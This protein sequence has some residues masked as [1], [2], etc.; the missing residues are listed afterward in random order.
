M[1]YVALC[2]QKLVRRDILETERKGTS[3]HTERAADVRKD[4]CCGCGRING[5]SVLDG[6]V[7]VRATLSVLTP[8]M[9]RRFVK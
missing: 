6:I 1:L 5:K 9:D 4:V 2:R 7:V 8:E 3:T